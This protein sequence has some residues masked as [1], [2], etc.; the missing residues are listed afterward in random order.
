MGIDRS[1]G[2]CELCNLNVVESEYHFIMCCPKF[3]DL[4][5]K[6]FGLPMPSINKFVAVMSST[7]KMKKNDLANFIK[8]A[9]KIG[10]NALHV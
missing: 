6:Y 3:S 8:E 1:Q 10:T 4:R 2:I 5:E 9:F 7:Q